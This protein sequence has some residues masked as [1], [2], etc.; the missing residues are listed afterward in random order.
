MDQNNVSPW[1][2]DFPDILTMK[3]KVQKKHKEKEEF[4]NGML[5]TTTQ[6]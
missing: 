4:N 6:Y 5:K 1:G 2:V 3:C